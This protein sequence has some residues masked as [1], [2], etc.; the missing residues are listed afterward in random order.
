MIV[1]IDLSLQK[2]G[3]KDWKNKNRK[4]HCF[5][6]KILLESVREKKKPTEKPKLKKTKNK[7][8]KQNKSKAKQN[9]RKQ[10][11]TQQPN[12]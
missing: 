4:K 3:E 12:K 2:E 6:S 9:K 11:Q 7:K 5:Q 8:Q 10:K 1:V